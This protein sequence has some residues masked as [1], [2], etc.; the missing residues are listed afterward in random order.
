VF[1]KG[2]AFL[3]QLTAMTKPGKVPVEFFIAEDLPLDPGLGVHGCFTA[4][5]D[6]AIEGDGYR[7]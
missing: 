7:C 6:T 5:L 2:D 3:S 4:L 1:G